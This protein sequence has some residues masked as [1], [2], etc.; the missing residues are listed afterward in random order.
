MG[1]IIARDIVFASPSRAIESIA[2]DGRN[3]SLT[4]DRDRYENIERDIP[5]M[6]MSDINIEQ[7]L[8]EISNWLLTD[9]GWHDFVWS[10]D[11]DFVYRAMCYQQYNINHLL[12]TVGKGIINFKF[13]PIKYLCS[14]LVEHPVMNNEVINNS[15]NIDA[16]PR[17]RILG[18]GNIDI[19]IGDQR[20]RLREIA[21]GGCIVDTESQTITS[22]D[23]Q[24]TI[25]NQ[26]YDGFPVL[27]PGN[28]RITFP[29]GVEMHMISRLGAL[30]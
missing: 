21:N 1:L 25:F 17:L 24:R 20:L 28:N 11:H 12:K 13:H 29:Q 14:G 2:V 5:V 22:L 9:V 18:S 16:E 23:G 7:R 15:Y 27:R 30:V 26:M 4:F 3:G 6:L 8:T 10:A 19:H